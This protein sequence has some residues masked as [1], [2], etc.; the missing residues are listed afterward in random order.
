MFQ[1]G[2]LTSVSYPGTTAGNETLSYDADGRLSTITDDS[3]SRSFNYDTLGNVIIAI[4]RYSGV[5]D[6]TISYE[7]YANGDVMKMLTPAGSFQYAYDANNR[8][9]QLTNPNGRKSRWSYDAEGRI[10]R[11]TLGNRAW[12]TYQYDSLKRISHLT[13]F[14]PALG[15]RRNTRRPTTSMPV[16]SPSANSIVPAR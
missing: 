8:L 4:T 16:A 3:G 12:T 15:S 11:Q 7:Y 10:T 5:P 2:L 6:Q 14:S 13:N 9:I 1:D